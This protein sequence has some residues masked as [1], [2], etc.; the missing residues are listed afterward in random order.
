MGR[1]SRLL[2]AQLAGGEAVGGLGGLGLDEIGDAEVNPMLLEP[3][4]VRLQGAAS[5]VAPPN[6][7]QPKKLPLRLPSSWLS[8]PGTTLFLL[9]FSYIPL[10]PQLCS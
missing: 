2:A 5:I 8:A 7:R 9:T 4:G 1:W 10:L 6:S 3:L